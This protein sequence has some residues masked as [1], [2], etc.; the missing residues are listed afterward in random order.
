MLQ[1][2]KI[3]VALACSM[4]TGQIL[5]L[6]TLNDDLMAHIT[7]QDGLT[8]Q[9][10]TDEITIEKVLWHDNDGLQPVLGN[11]HG[12]LVPQAGA[13][14]LNNIKITP[15]NYLSPFAELRMDVDGGAGVQ[16]AMLN[17]GMDLAAMNI[18]VE[19]IGVGQSESEPTL[20]VNTTARRGISRE[21]KILD[22][23][24]ISLGETNM[25][26]QLG[27]LPNG[28]FMTVYGKIEDG[29]SI[30]NL[31][32]IADGASASAF[33]VKE[34]RIKDAGIGNDDLSFNGVGVNIHAQ[35]GIIITP[36]AGKIIDIGMN[37]FSF[38][39]SSTNTASAIGNIFMSGLVLGGQKIS[40][41][42]H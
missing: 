2:K 6:Q 18:S 3:I 14:V 9:F 4:V 34:M 23:F 30:S 22:G 16:A 10:Q 25:N 42:G 15:D 21:R 12:V 27:H 20:G 28:N 39:G 7:G 11:S 13:L 5:A 32:V 1:Y 36:S 26:I 8:I 17:I 24:V 41:I 40:I 37:E 33:A 31:N 35:G 38:G 29:I 19:S